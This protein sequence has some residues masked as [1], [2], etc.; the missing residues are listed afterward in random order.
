MTDQTVQSSN[1][2]PRTE[3]K[4]KTDTETKPK[5]EPKAEP[6]PP[7][8]LRGMRGVSSKKVH[9]FAVQAVD[10][11]SGKVVWQ[12][13]V[14]EEVPHERTHPDGTWA[15]N[16][17]VCDGERVYALFGSRGLHCLDMDGKPLWE[18]DLGKMSIRMQFGE[19]SSPALHGDTIVVNWDHERQSFIVAFDKKTGKELWKVDRDEPPCRHG[20]ESHR[21]PANCRKR[22]ATSSSSGEHYKSGPTK[23]NVCRRPLGKHSEGK[24]AKADRQ[25]VRNA[26]CHTRKYV[27]ECD[28]S[29]DDQWV[30]V[31]WCGKS[32]PGHHSP[33]QG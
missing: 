20:T 4:P 6:D 18:K 12:R 7:R 29:D 14:R 30:A 27:D 32:R 5:T 10:R 23:R 8:R 13:T 19:G 2:W 11:R 21:R 22:F 33:Q 25:Q 28:D 15:S 24:N 16:S 9:A 31:C 3:P 1:A 17:P 26:T